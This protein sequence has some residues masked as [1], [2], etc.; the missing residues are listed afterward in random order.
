MNQKGRWTFR[1]SFSNIFLLIVA[2]LINVLGKWLAT[3]FSLPFWLDAVGTV[4]A[5]GLLGPLAGG[6]VGGISGSVCAMMTSVSLLYALIN[7][8]IGVIVGILYPEDTTDLFQILCTAAIVAIVAIVVSTPINLLLYHGYTG[9]K[10]GDALFDMLQQSGNSR[11]FSSALG[12]ALV[13]F[14]D[15]V[16]SFFLAT[17]VAKVWYRV[18]PVKKE[19]CA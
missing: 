7:I 6:L 3:T 10:W 8:V 14:P 2:F 19:E 18:N 13:D 9:N 15:K 4:F 17:G 11:I 5:A 1:L 12:Q 16:I